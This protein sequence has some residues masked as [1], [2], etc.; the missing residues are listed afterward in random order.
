M[1]AESG[2]VSISGPL[3]EEIDHHGGFELAAALERREE[4]AADVV[5]LDDGVLVGV[6][7]GERPRKS[8]WG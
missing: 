1:K 2:H 6:P 4:P 7:G 3:S 5:E 8:G